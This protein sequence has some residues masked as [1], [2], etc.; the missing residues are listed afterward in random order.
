MGAAFSSPLDEDEANVKANAFFEDT[1]ALI[2][3]LEKVG[4]EEAHPTITSKTLWTSTDPVQRAALFQGALLR[5]ETG[6]MYGVNTTEVMG[7]T[8]G[9]RAKLAGSA[10]VVELT[11]EFL[12]GSEVLGVWLHSLSS[13]AT[14]NVLQLPGSS[15]EFSAELAVDDAA[16]PFMLVRTAGGQVEVAMDVFLTSYLRPIT[17]WAVR[18]S[19]PPTLRQARE[20]LVGFPAAGFGS[21]VDGLGIAVPFTFKEGGPPG[22]AMPLGGYV[23]LLVDLTCGSD[24]GRSVGP[25]ARGMMRSVLGVDE[26]TTESFATQIQAGNVFELPNIEAAVRAAD[27]VLTIPPGLRAEALGKTKADL[28]VLPIAIRSIRAASVLREYAIS[29]AASSARPEEPDAAGGAGGGGSGRSTST[30]ELRSELLEQLRKGQEDMLAQLQATIRGVMLGGAPAPAPHAHHPAHAA[31]PDAHGTLHAGHPARTAAPGALGALPADVDDS[32]VWVVPRFVPAAARGMSPSAIY[33]HLSATNDGPALIRTLA[34]AVGKPPEALLEAIRP[35]HTDAAAIA[36]ATDVLALANELGATLS[37][38]TEVSGVTDEA[39]AALRREMHAVPADWASAQAKINLLVSTVYSMRARRVTMGIAL[40]TAGRPPTITT[41]SS[42]PPQGSLSG[43]F[44]LDLAVPPKATTA[45]GHLL[46]ALGGEKVV[47]AEH[48]RPTPL[49][50]DDANEAEARRIVATYEQA[51]W[52]AL[53]SAPGTVTGEEVPGETICASIPACAARL[54]SSMYVACSGE[55]GEAKAKG[56]AKATVAEA[57]QVLIYLNFTRDLET[58]AAGKTTY[59]WVGKLIV[60]F[61][62]T[63]ATEEYTLEGQTEGGGSWGSVASHESVRRA[64]Q[65]VEALLIRFHVDA[66]GSPEA[67]DAP[68]AG[69]GSIVAPARHVGLL[70]LYDDAYKEV[71][72]AR[73]LEMVGRALMR[74]DL[75]AQ[76][77]RQVTGG[78]GVDLVEEIEW[79]RNKGMPR[80]KQQREV[81]RGVDAE[82]AARMPNIDQLIQTSVDA[83]VAQALAAFKART[84][85]TPRVTGAKEKAQPTPA[86]PRPPPAKSPKKTRF[87]ADADLAVAAEVEE[88]PASDDAAFA[89]AIAKSSPKTLHPS[90]IDEAARKAAADLVAKRP[91]APAAPAKPT[92]T[93]G[94]SSNEQVNAVTAYEQH[95]AGTSHAD[96][97]GF[98]TLFG[99]CKK[100][101][102][103]RCTKCVTGK[104]TGVGPASAVAAVKAAAKVNAPA[105]AESIVGPPT[106]SPK[107]AATDAPT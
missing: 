30:S 90:I 35:L 8:G 28:E 66:G 22:L 81:Q 44:K 16:Q 105:V 91:G 103:G 23:S 46:A 102:D 79:V 57:A 97:C 10:D 104:M 41:S 45:A 32:R 11:D 54:V 65:V 62:G 96:T 59:P 82:V 55:V 53:F 87:A 34:A 9:L 37:H 18:P 61:G 88:T 76:R 20:I 27:K 7:A 1:H 13:P 99:K 60:V 77:A 21:L 19:Q 50:G 86:T 101:A 107:V 63:D 25:I 51:G 52:A 24:H 100:F 26:Y 78:G 47:H 6:A 68:S 94:K 48:A 84:P 42:K 4:A 31:V 98:Y 29:L 3:A 14:R 40:P 38:G 15:V 69:R 17:P 83:K 95:V 74:I 43:K 58:S 70:K 89:A 56:E 12:S 49:P 39:A 106:T 75:A 64:L 85:Q 80:H 5:C 67:T 73:A 71:E 72:R 93:W 92:G 33:T 36:S 2:E